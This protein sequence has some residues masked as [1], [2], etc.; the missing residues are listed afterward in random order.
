[1]YVFTA[2][3][4][5]KH[6]VYS[7][8]VNDFESDWSFHSVASTS[9]ECKILSSLIRILLHLL[10]NSRSV[11]QDVSVASNDNI[12]SLVQLRKCSSCLCAYQFCIRSNDNNNFYVLPLSIPY[13]VGLH[14]LNY[15][16]VLWNVWRLSIHKNRRHGIVVCFSKTACL[17]W[18]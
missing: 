6:V 12:L 2:I 3:T 11:Y 18:I 14:F 5:C 1:M 8:S 9:T 13:D 7:R 4:I 16:S 17:R 10:K 15:Q